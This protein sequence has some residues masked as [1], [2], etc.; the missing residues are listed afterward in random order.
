MIG[1]MP[2]PMAD[3]MRRYNMLRRLVGV[4]IFASLVIVA[5]PT[6]RVFACSCIQITPAIALANAD[7]AFVGV[8]A[9]VTDAKAGN[10]VIGSGDPIVYTFA[11]EQVVKGPAAVQID[12]SSPRDGASCGQ[13]FSL[14]ERW[15]V[16]ASADGSGGLATGICSGNE[17]LGEN[18]PLPPVDPPAPPIGLLLVVAAVVLLGAVSA[19][20]FTRRSR[21]AA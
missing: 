16:F 20:A 6:A 4:A 19:W 15:R 2:E 21:N 12:L 14:A 11:V 9:G 1:A 3:P 13:T 10:P 18:A 7:V 5:G 8:V 17:L